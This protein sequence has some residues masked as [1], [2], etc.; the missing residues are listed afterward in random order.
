MNSIEVL[1]GG[2]GEGSMSSKQPY[3]SQWES[4]IDVLPSIGWNSSSG[5]RE[6]V[7]VPL[8]MEVH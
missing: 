7:T 3:L 8:R 6:F 1:I 2:E 5:T 4:T